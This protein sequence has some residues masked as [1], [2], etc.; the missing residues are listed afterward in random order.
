M[1]GNSSPE[2]QLVSSL[3]RIADVRDI[4]RPVT[5]TGTASSLNEIVQ[6]SFLAV[7]GPDVCSL[8]LLVGGLTVPDRRPTAYICADVTICFDTSWYYSLCSLLINHGLQN[9]DKSRIHG[10]SY[11]SRTEHSRK[12][13]F[14]S[15]LRNTDFLIFSSNKMNGCHRVNVSQS[16]QRDHGQMYIDSCKNF[17]LRIEFYRL[18]I[19]HVGC[20][21]KNFSK[22][23]NI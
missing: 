7:K 17:S 2:R 18:F 5:F 3:P 20:T 23:C 1:N 8:W 22:L 21:V 14:G 13:G 6:T 19:S 12:Y 15:T 10:K 16:G 9:T 11:K 4:G